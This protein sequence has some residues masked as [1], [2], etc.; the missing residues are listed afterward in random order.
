MSQ[1]TENANRKYFENKKKIIPMGIKDIFFSES[2]IS[3][4]YTANNFLYIGRLIDY[5]GVGLLIDCMNL[6]NNENY[7]FKLDILGSGIDEKD[8]KEKVRTL[9]LSKNIIFHGFKTF[10]RRLNFIR[11]QM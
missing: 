1:I 11:S 10:H 2:G 3:K 6:L 9:N 5:K 8:L 4:K 7:K